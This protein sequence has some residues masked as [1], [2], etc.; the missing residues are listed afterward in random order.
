MLLPREITIHMTEGYSQTGSLM[1]LQLIVILFTFPLLVENTV[2][3]CVQVNIQK[4][5]SVFEI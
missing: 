1:A 2:T 4:L 5:T 3:L